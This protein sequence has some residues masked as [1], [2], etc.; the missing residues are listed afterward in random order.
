MSMHLAEDVS[1][2]RALLPGLQKF[3]ADL[4]TLLWGGSLRQ[5]RPEKYYM[6]G[7]GPKWREKHARPN[8]ISSHVQIPVMLDQKWD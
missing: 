7:P 6:R 8:D 4:L 3:A 2:F 5:Y 1:R